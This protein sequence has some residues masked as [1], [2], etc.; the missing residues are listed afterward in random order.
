MC[1]VIDGLDNGLWPIQWWQSPLTQHYYKLLIID[2]CLNLTREPLSQSLT[3]KHRFTSETTFVEQTRFKL[4][5]QMG[6][7]SSQQYCN[8]LIQLNT[9]YTSGVRFVQQCDENHKEDLKGIEIVS[10]WP[11]CF[12]VCNVYPI[13]FTFPDRPLLG[14]WYSI[15]FY[16]TLVCL[17]VLSG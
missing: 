3:I 2:W 5:G 9:F 11:L 1:W 15:L 8:A 16:S 13:P 14:Q 6:A 12:R 7:L 17:R 10:I 4:K